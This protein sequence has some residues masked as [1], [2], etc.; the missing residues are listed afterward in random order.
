MAEVSTMDLD[1]LEGEVAAEYATFLAERTESDAFDP[2]SWITWPSTWPNGRP[3]L[4][5]QFP[6]P[7]WVVYPNRRKVALI[8]V[9][10]TIRTV[11]ENPNGPNATELTA[12]AGFLL[13]YGGREAL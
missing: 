6:R 7:R 3:A 8:L 11:S 2:S 9:R 4:G 1:V 5:L 12:Y 10:H 13:V